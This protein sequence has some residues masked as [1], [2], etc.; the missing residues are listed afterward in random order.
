MNRIMRFT[1]GALAFIGALYLVGAILGTFAFL[2]F[3]QALPGVVTLA[4]L[5]VGAGLV[6]GGWWLHRVFDNRIQPHLDDPEFETD[7]N[8]A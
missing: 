1:G 5:V 4:H 7:I 6:A 2:V 8:D 3:Y